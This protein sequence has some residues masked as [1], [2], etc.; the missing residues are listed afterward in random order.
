MINF[1]QFLENIKNLYQNTL[2]NAP[3][4][5]NRI[6]NQPIKI[7]AIPNTEK[8]NITFKAQVPGSNNENYTTIVKFLNVNFKEPTKQPTLN[9]YTLKSKT[10]NY[11][12]NLLSKNTH[13]VQ[14]SCNCMH[15][16][17]RLKNTHISHKTLADAKDYSTPQICKHILKVIQYLENKGILIDHYIDFDNNNMG[18]Y[19]T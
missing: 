18:D 11:Y 1:Q 17:N 14:V 4:I 16:T 8:N 13:N 12:F 10:N 15:F 3:D 6:D 19:N 5:N 9:T 2:A 7:N